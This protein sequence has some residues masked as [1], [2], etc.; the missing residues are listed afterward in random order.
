MVSSFEAISSAFVMVF[1]G[2]YRS[3]LEINPLFHKPLDLE[4][5]KLKRCLFRSVGP[6]LIVEI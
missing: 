2:L 5:G 3:I 4:S 6:W 1:F